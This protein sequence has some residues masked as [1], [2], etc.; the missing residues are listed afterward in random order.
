VTACAMTLTELPLGEALPSISRYIRPATR[1]PK[2]V[3]M[4]Q[5]RPDIPLAE[6]LAAMQAELHDLAHRQLARERANHTLQTTALVN[7]A[8]LRLVEQRNLASADRPTFLA[9][10]A[11]T[12]RRVLVDHARARQRQKRGGGAVLMSLNDAE[13]ADRSRGVDVLDLHAAMEDLAADHPRAARVVEL[14][15]FAGLS[16]EETAAALNVSPRTVAG[17]WSFARAWLRRAMASYDQQ[18]TR[19]ST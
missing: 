12:I 6:M 7:E 18:R 19:K 16:I 4:P 2:A 13:H 9:A 3:T 8:F 1:A 11:Q 14:R 15:F 17:D 5:P 10:A